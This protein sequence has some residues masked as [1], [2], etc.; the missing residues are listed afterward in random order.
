MQSLSVGDLLGYYSLRCRCLLDF[1]S[2]ARKDD[3]FLLFFLLLFPF[4]FPSHD[5]FSFEDTQDSRRLAEDGK[6]IDGRIPPGDP[7]IPDRTPS[8]KTYSAYLL[9]S[10]FSIP[11]RHVY[12]KTTTRRRRQG[13]KGDGQEKKKRKEKTVLPWRPIIAIDLR[14]IRRREK[15]R[16][17][18]L[19][20]IIKIGK[21]SASS[22]TGIPSGKCR[23]VGLP[24]FWNGQT[25]WP[26]H[27]W[28][29]Q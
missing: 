18:S 4:L 27:C 28:T 8:T 16:A 14:L 22:A 19:K 9:Y 13:R 7:G 15:G 2:S 10:L 23:Y 24:C 17:P 5:Y 26:K 6:R 11:S 1:C 21:S 29:A 25:Q 12:E 20:I 3:S